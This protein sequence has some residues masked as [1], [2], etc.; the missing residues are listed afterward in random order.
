V[1]IVL[2]DGTEAMRMALLDTGRAYAR[3]ITPAHGIP[4]HGAD[5]AATRP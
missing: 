1:S 2:I 3:D 4:A 5:I